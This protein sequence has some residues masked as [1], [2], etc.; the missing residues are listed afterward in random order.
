MS[1]TPPS[2]A[3]SAIYSQGDFIF[4]Q[5]HATKGYTTELSFSA[6]PGG[7][8]ALLRVLREREMELATSPHKIAGRTMPIQHV[9]DAWAKDPDV[10][11]KLK[12]A[13]ERAKRERFRSRPLREQLEELSRMFD[14]N[15][16]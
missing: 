2:H 10:E 3:A 14:D 8:A 15:D 9:V 5:L 4:L 6:A 16:L 12:R 11:A 1:R 7:M 13:Q